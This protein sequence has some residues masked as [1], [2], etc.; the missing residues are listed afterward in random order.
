MRGKHRQPRDAKP[1]EGNRVDTGNN[2]AKTDGER[3]RSGLSKWKSYC[4]ERFAEQGYRSVD[5]CIDA[6]RG[7]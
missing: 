4:G 7:T 1:N 5:E 2:G 3:A 6:I